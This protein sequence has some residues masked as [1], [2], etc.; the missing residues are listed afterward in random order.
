[1]RLLLLAAVR[2]YQV[3]LSPWLGPHCRYHPTCSA[4]AAEAIETHGA[5]RGLVMALARI[6]RCHPFH[7][8]GYDPV[9]PRSR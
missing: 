4:Y 1:M 7:R 2:A 8:G 5:L 6:S 3:F 9:P